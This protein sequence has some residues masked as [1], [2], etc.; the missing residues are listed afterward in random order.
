MEDVIGIICT[1]FC[2]WV[3]GSLLVAN[4]RE[5]FAN[6]VIRKSRIKE[7]IRAVSNSINA[8]LNEQISLTKANYT[9][10]RDMAL[11]QLP[12]LKERMIRDVRR[13]VYIKNVLPYKGRKSIGYKKKRR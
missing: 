12:G 1:I 10:L 9:L 4:I 5:S 13:Q 11:Q 3:L 2:L 6:R 7:E 8:H